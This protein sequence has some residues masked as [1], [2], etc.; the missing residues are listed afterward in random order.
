MINTRGGGDD[1][2]GIPHSLLREA[3]RHYPAR[4]GASQL[5]SDSRRR[6]RRSSRSG[7]G[8]APERPY[9]GRRWRSQAMGG[10]ALDGVAKPGGSLFGDAIIA[11]LLVN[12]VRHRTVSWVF[13]T[14]RE[15]SNHM[16][17][18]AIGSVADGVQGTAA[19]VLAAGALPSIG[20]VVIGA[21]A[22]KET[23]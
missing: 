5:T 15:A 23:A 17:A 20:A 9:V 22:L 14:P 3:P 7:D 4:S 6:D 18:I 19:R 12:E 2:A 16:T 11:F 8:V 13:G 10:T 1:I 21:A